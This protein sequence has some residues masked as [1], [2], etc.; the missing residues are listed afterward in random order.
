MINNV[1]T[2]YELHSGE[3]CIG[4]EFHGLEPWIIRRALELLESTG[5]VSRQDKRQTCCLTH[6][7]RYLSWRIS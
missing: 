6:V 2:V 1:Y 3:D 7:G 5:K 4:T